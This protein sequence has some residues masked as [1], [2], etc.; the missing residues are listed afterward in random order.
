ME[1]ATAIRIFL[2][3]MVR[4]R[5]LPFTPSLSPKGAGDYNSKENSVEMENPT[6]KAWLRNAVQIGLDALENNDYATEEEVAETFRK[7]GVNVR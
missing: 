5:A 4:E 7:A 1:V 3:Q 2:C 6:R